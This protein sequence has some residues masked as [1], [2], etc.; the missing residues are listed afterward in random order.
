MRPQKP[1]QEPDQIR[2]QLERLG[3][4]EPITLTKAC[5][6]RA[7]PSTVRWI[8]DAHDGTVIDLEPEN[9]AAWMPT[10]PRYKHE[11]AEPVGTP[12]TGNPAAGETQPLEDGLFLEIEDPDPWAQDNE[13][14]FW[15]D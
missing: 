5:T 1:V 10:A 3:L 15:T 7:P 2:R 4:W 12:A 14:I 9:A 13:P 8:L 11:R 6:P